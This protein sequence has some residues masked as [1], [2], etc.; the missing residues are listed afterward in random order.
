[1]VVRVASSSA[2][3]VA[4]AI[5]TLTREFS[6]PR[7]RLKNVNLAVTHLFHAQKGRIEEEQKRIISEGLRRV[8]LTKFHKF[9]QKRIEERNFHPITL[10]FIKNEMERQLTLPLNVALH[11][12]LD[13]FRDDL[14]PKLDAAI[15]QAMADSTALEEIGR[16]IRAIEEQGEKEAKLEQSNRGEIRSVAPEIRQEARQV[17]ELGKKANYLRNQAKKESQ[18]WYERREVQAVGALVGILT[19]MGLWLGLRPSPPKVEGK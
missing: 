14:I 6:R 3:L 18:S 1:M 13:Q 17:A 8:P 10:L 15:V 5:T 7:I 2:D 12:M 9:F 19:I 16:E 4:R 11:K